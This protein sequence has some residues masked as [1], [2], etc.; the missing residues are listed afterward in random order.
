MHQEA[1]AESFLALRPDRNVPGAH[2]DF[3][4]LLKVWLRPQIE[5]VPDAAVRAEWIRSSSLNH[6]AFDGLILALGCPKR[7]LVPAR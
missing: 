2:R 6:R 3:P 4:V 7:F 5:R 1:S